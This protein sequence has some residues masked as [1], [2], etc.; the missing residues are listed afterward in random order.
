MNK[1]RIIK[2]L[3]LAGVVVG[4]CFLLYS[5]WPSIDRA[6]SQG[7]EAV[8]PPPV[9]LEMVGVWENEEE[10]ID[11]NPG[12]LRLIISSDGVLDLDYDHHKYLWFFD[13]LHLRVT[14]DTAIVWVDPSQSKEHKPISIRIQVQD[15]RLTI[16]D[17]WPNS[18][19]KFR[20]ISNP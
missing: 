2:T 13:R 16:R 6:F 18:V 5:L 3:F 14:G 7:W 10:L 12:D 17:F 20:R 15:D 19:L 1:R 11:A 4:S 9:P 8:F